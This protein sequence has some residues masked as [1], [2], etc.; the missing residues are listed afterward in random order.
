MKITRDRRKVRGLEEQLLEPGRLEPDPSTS[1][2][3][4]K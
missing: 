3:F 2:S 4:F 1:M